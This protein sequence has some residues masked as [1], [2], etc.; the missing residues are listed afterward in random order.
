MALV[1]KSFPNAR[2]AERYS[3]SID[4]TLRNARAEPQDVVIDDLS[5]TGFRINSGLN[6]AVDDEIT[7]GVFGVG[8]R[9]ARVLRACDN[10]F[11]CQFVVPLNQSELASALGGLTPPEPIPLPVVNLIRAVGGEVVVEAEWSLSPRL[12]MATI[13]AVGVVPWLMLGFAW[14]SFA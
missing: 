11:G 10:G 5:A 7:L 2:A 13:A 8:L 6:V 4:G 9:A 12:R 14:A 3:V 1:A